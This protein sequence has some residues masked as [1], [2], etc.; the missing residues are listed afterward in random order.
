METVTLK[1]MPGDKCYVYGQNRTCYIESISITE[2][3]IFYFWCNY[4][5]GV[6]CTEV[7]DEDCF[8]AKDIGVTVFDSMEELQ[9]TFSSLDDFD[10]YEYLMAT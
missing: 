2:Q 8:T 7:W 6:D 9:K 3:D 4:D 1:Y 5:V 10:Y